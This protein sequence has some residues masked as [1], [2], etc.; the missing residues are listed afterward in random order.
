MGSRLPT[1]HL[2]RHGVNTVFYSATPW[3]RSGRKRAD[4]GARRGQA[5][6]LQ[7]QHHH[8]PAACLDRLV[9]SSFSSLS[10]SFSSRPQMTEVPAV[11]ELL[12]RNTEPHPPPMEPRL[13]L[14]ATDRTR[15]TRREATAPYSLT[16]LTRTLLLP[17]QSW[18]AGWKSSPCPL[19]ASLLT[20]PPS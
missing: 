6:L 20:P 11:M 9:S 15:A 1:S 10:F 8:Q 17:N 18:L 2:P 19:S 5:V 12:L 16:C 3:A 4:Q 7:Q 14:M 13:R